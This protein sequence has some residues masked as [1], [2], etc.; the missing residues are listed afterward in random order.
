MAALPIIEWD[1]YHHLILDVHEKQYDRVKDYIMQ[2]YLSNELYQTLG[3]HKDP[4]FHKDLKTLIKHLL[5]NDSSLMVLDVESDSINGIALLKCMS[6]EWRSWTS[7]QVL[8]NNQH[9][10]ELI[11]FPRYSVQDY[12]AE[13][14][15]K[16]DGLHI[17]YYH[18]EPFLGANQCFMAKFFNA[19]ANVAKHMHMPRITYMALSLKDA[20]LLEEM[21]YKEVKRILYSMYV[22]K[23]RRPFDHLRDLNEMHGSLYEFKVEPLKHFEELYPKH[24]LMGEN[25]KDKK[26]A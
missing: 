22:Y 26:V 7:L 14:Q 4:E 5:E 25:V 12:A 13:Q 18:V 17:F 6:E 3:Y 24:G 15:T 21:S 19:I 1:V 23:G 8:I 20:A 9:L 11:D 16:W 10:K 2:H